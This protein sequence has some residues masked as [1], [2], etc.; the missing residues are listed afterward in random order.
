MFSVVE[1]GEAFFFL[2]HNR[3]TEYM[4]P[5]KGSQKFALAAYLLLGKKL[6]K[7]YL[8]QNEKQVPLDLMKFSLKRAGLHP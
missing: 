2:I 4:N 3:I 5:E 1:V 6:V 7:I 8:I